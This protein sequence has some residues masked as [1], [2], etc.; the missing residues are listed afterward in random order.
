MKERMGIQERLTI[1]VVDSTGHVISTAE[2]YSGS[3]RHRISKWLGL[4]CFCDDIVL[5]AGLADIAAYLIDEYHYMEFGNGTTKPEHDDTDL[6]NALFSRCVTTNSIV[7]TFYTN[8]TARFQATIVPTY[9]ATFYE[10][11]LCKN[12]TSGGSDVVF[13]RETFAPQVV[14]NGVTMLANWDVVV[15]R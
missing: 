6:E 1:N 2:P 13:A 7:T 3:W 11:I 4:G 5:D 10:A 9:D 8:D 12:A 15:M 14:A